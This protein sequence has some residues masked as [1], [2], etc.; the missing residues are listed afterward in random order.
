MSQ[1]EERAQAVVI[2]YC[3]GREETWPL[4]IE[5]GIADAIES[6]VREAA[7]VASEPYGDAV[8]CFGQDEP[9]TVSKKIVAAILAHFDLKEK[10]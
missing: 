8:A 9:L 2:L 6:A 10:P 3:G 5:A 1:I 4:G 7:R